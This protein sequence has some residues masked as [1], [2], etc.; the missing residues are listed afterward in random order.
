MGINR[1]L[2]PSDSVNGIGDSAFSAINNK[3]NDQSGAEFHLEW[4]VNQY[5]PIGLYAGVGGYFY[6]QFTGDIAPIA[7]IG[8]FKGQVASVG[9][10]VGYTFKVGEQEV[11]LAGRWFHEFAVENRVRGDSVFASISFRL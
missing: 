3:T 8:P 1:R 2:S 6:R 11:N 5:L 7:I 9:P 4:A 10:L